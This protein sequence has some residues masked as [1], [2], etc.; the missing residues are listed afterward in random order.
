MKKREDEPKNHQ[1]KQQ[2][3]HHQQLP[4]ISMVWILQWE[5]YCTYCLGIWHVLYRFT[6]L[7]MLMARHLRKMTLNQCCGRHWKRGRK[8]NRKLKQIKSRKKQTI[9]IILRLNHV[10]PLAMFCVQRTH[11]PI[12]LS[13]HP[14]EY[15]VISYSHST[16]NVSP[17]FSFSSLDTFISMQLYGMELFAYAL[18]CQHG[19][20][21]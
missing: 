3:Q 19:F 7:N 14:S 2:H 11:Q 9:T 8:I 17:V 18:V 5:F 20:S 6:V 4:L 1:L 21:M 15:S 10:T 12:Y 16:C 13:I